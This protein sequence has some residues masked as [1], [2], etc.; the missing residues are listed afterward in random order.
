L[1][2]SRSLDWSGLGDSGRNGTV[3]SGAFWTRVVVKVSLHVIVLLAIIDTS[4]TFGPY[5]AV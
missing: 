5:I 1:N 2:T 4:I 3:K